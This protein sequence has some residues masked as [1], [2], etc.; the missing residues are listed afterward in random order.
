M[1]ARGQRDWLLMKDPLQI[2]YKSPHN[3]PRTTQLM[4]VASSTSWAPWSMAPK[5]R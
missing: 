3:E 1:D 5:F 2:R 4:D